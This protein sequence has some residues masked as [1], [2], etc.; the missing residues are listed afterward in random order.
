MTSDS[1]IIWLRKGEETGRS[2]NRGTTEETCRPVSLVS[3][4]ERLSGMDKY[5]NT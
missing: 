3:G 2:L 4:S 1:H 5:G